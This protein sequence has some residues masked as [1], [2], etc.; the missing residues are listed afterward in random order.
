MSNDFTL[1]L[2]EFLVTGLAF[3][4]LAVDF[5]VRPSRA[6]L[7]GY[8]SL[9]G[10]VGILA[11]TLAFLWGKDD[12][13][14]D[15]MIV[16]DGFALFFKAFFLVL[17]G[18]AILASV[19]Y[20]RRHLDHA[21]EYYAIILFTVVAM[22]LLASASELL[23]A[24]VALELLSF[25]LY[26]LVSFD[27]YNPKSNEGG[28]KYILLGALSSAILLYGISQIYGLAGTTRFDEI[29][30]V[31]VATSDLSPGLLV[32][33]VF[34]IAGLGFKVA[35]VP[36]HMWA[37]DAYEGAPTPVT[38]YLAVGSK[39]AAFVL[40]LKIFVEAL[41]PAAADWQLILVIMAALTMTLGNLGA[42]VQSNIKRLLAYSSIG[43]VGYLLMGI[44]ALAAVDSSRIASI[45]ASQLVVAAVIFHLAAY[46]V[47]NMAA[48]LA[49][50]TIQDATGKEEIKDLAGIAR[51]A[52]WVAMIL[53][54]SLFSLAGLPIFAGFT[55]K[56][57]LF[58]AAATQGLLWLAGLAIFAS[59]ISLYYY[60]SVV[61]RLY[62]EPPED[63]TPVRVPKMTFGVLGV[64]L[65]GII[66][67]GVYP[68][69]LLDAIQHASQ[70]ILSSDGPLHL[71][72]SVD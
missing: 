9:A 55:S 49:V 2:P 36:F 5:F 21:G 53:A 47:T 18:V 43:H 17:G 31:L 72:W 38:A 32:G 63:P 35:A 66:F 50:S 14:Y 62:I 12:G 22:M 13:L 70:A 39:A 24:Y 25:G 37:P 51:R 40:V 41:M 71:V 16:I 64:L 46:G 20:V 19:E 44:A 28:T 60:L 48:F 29:S 33:L 67:L 26:V 45:E 10:L 6:H 59:L 23:T 15:D 7:L 30:D 57:Y 34:I 58:T 61:R 54:V 68:A 27:R 69:P 1:L 3:L 8:V 52:P 11:F 42:L 65:I 56:F 4:V